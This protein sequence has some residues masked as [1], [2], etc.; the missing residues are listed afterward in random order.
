MTFGEFFPLSVT[1]TR[2]FHAKYVL[3]AIFLLLPLLF[4]TITPAIENISAIAMRLT[5]SQKQFLLESGNGE[6]LNK[7]QH[8][9]L[10]TQLVSGKLHVILSVWG[11]IFIKVQTK[12]EIT[13]I[14][15]L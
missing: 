15:M 12:T 14:K 13:R 6:I 1:G 9:T 10:L 7:L 3:C 4:I 5:S 11:D 8:L 2:R